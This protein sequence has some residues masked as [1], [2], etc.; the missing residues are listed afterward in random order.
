[1][2]AGIVGV[3]LLAGWISWLV[4]AR[5]DVYRV[6]ADARIEVT[7]AP[8]QVAASTTGRVVHVDLS[9]GAR[10]EA[11]HPLVVLDTTSEVASLERA[12]AKLEA[13]APELA[14]IDREVESELLLEGRG[15]AGDR[16]TER[17]VL[18]RQRGAEAELLR[19]QD[20]T[21]RVRALVESGALPAAE[22]SRATTDEAK[23]RSTYDAITHESKARA[24]D[25]GQRAAARASRREQLE[26]QRLEL[27]GEQSEIAGEIERLTLV[28]ERSTIRAPFAGMLGAVAPV[29]PGGVLSVGDVVATVV[30]DGTLQVAAR[31]PA[32]SIG[33]IVPGQRAQIRL[34]AF[35]WTSYGAV[36]AR[37]ERVG[38]EL[39]DGFIRVELSLTAETGGIA[40]AHGMT[41][42]VEI[43]V[44]QTS[45]VDLL[46]RTLGADR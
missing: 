27:V 15:D 13:L 28:I 1:M 35:P 43:Q 46:A 9:V 25:R 7:P 4:A 3:L 21:I 22:L 31:Y 2:F 36:P 5:V 18:A 34:D 17:E 33:R 10:V 23:R 40:L 12:R 26:R 45:P 38:S 24:S 32:A 14:S 41:G 30:P 29:R 8:T 11:G 6:S 19:A 37:V 20:E 39:Q 42:Q 16:E 44:E